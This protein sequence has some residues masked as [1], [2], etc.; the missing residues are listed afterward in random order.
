MQKGYVYVLVSL[1]DNR[2]YVGSTNN[3]SR[4]IADHNKGK[5]YSTKN[6]LPMKLTYTEELDNLH[7]A[8]LREKYYKSHAGRTQLKRLLN[9]GV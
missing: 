1:K 6:R 2:T 3:V 8:R 7:L 9:I 5:V 4:R